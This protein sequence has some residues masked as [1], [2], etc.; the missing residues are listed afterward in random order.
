[1]DDIDSKM[2]Y[3][4]GYFLIRANH[5]GWEQLR[6]ALIPAKLISLSSC[7]CPMFNVNWG[8]VTGDKQSALDFGIAEEAIDE[9]LDWCA[10][11]YKQ[12]VDIWS[13]FYTPDNARQFINRFKVDIDQLYIIGV[14]LPQ[15]FEKVTGKNHVMMS[16][17]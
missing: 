12:T 7:I 5:P 1:M 2:F 14:G 8:W 9:F 16:T 15:A 13:M 10:E 17:A 11:D 6:S 3:S 4:G